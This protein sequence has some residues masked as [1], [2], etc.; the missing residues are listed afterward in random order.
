MKDGTAL[1]EQCYKKMTAAWLDAASVVFELDDDK[2]ALKEFRVAFGRNPAHIKKA[3]ERFP[4]YWDSDSGADLF[5]LL[6]TIHLSKIKDD[7]QALEIYERWVNDVNL[8]YDSLKAMVK[9]AHPAKPK[10]AATCERCATVNELGATWYDEANNVATIS[11]ERRSVLTQC[12][13]QLRRAL[14][15]AVT[16]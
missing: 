14:D 15:E 8:D 16:P 9:S 2:T 5:T 11:S 10:A 12:A 1:G 7:D 13:N 6:A 3:V 4:A